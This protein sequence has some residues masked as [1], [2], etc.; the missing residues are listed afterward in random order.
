MIGLNFP[1]DMRLAPQFGAMLGARWIRVVLLP[2][3]DLTPW[4][5]DAHARG[6][7][8]LGVI[9]REST[10]DD[11]GYPSLAVLYGGRYAGLIDAIQCGN[12]SDHESPSS[13][14]MAQGDLNDLLAAFNREFPDTTIVGP[15]LA[16]GN[17]H[18]LDAVD[19]D[20]VDAIAV[21]PYGRWPNNGDWSEL[22]GGFGSIA[23]LLDQ[24]RYHNR[25]IW[26]TEL[27]VSTHQVSEEFQARYVEECLK[28][29]KLR[30]DV[31]VVT[32]FCA[33]D[34]M[35]EEFG[36]FDING[37][38][39]VASTSF[40]KVAKGDTPMP[41]YSQWQGQI[42]TGLLDMMKDDN[43]LPA[44]RKSTFLPLGTQ[45]SDIEEAHGQNGILYVWHLD[46]SGSYRFAP[47]Q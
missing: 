21:H 14:T 16:S 3:V 45:P 27:G 15:G 2:D 20:L 46:G 34:A 10:L 41:D 43:T 23:E 31:P 19:L 35:V 24:Y 42:G 13:W 39:K 40:M 32:W 22:P 25:P 30:T 17:P 12:E 28:S 37:S 33:D 29:L 4:I 9:A 26:I 1:A 44:Q 8:V 38:P 36:L 7:K 11:M 5:T 6:L 47:D 18:Y